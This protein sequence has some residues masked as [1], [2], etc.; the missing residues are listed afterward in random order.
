MKNPKEGAAVDAIPARKTTSKTGI[1]WVHLAN[2]AQLGGKPI[3]AAKNVRLTQIKAL[4]LRKTPP[5][6]DDT[7]HI[8]V[9]MRDSAINPK[10]GVR[11]GDV[12]FEWIPNTPT[13]TKEG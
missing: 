12:Y 8:E 5:F 10:D 13:T 9:V 11:Y 2:V 1:D 4:R 3:L 7:G 6:R